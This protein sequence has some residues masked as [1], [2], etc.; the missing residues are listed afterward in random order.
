VTGLVIAQGSVWAAAGTSAGGSVLEIDPADGRVI[1]RV[2]LGPVAPTA[3][4]VAD[5]SVWVAETTNDSVIRLNSSSLKPVGTTP[6]RQRPSWEP[7]QLTVMF[8]NVWVYVRGAAIAL[9]ASTGHLR[10][11]Q[12]FT[13][14]DHRR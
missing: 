2:D 13:P 10:Y 5:G 7:T 9:S 12:P 11:T 1:Q 3:I 8:G 6:L 14:A 4:T